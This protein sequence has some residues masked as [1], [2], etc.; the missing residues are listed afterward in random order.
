MTVYT[1]YEPGTP[2]GDLLEGVLELRVDIHPN[3]KTVFNKPL[4]N[5]EETQHTETLAQME[6]QY[7]LEEKKIGF[8]FIP[9]GNIPV[10]LR[11]G[12]IEAGLAFFLSDMRIRI[13][14]V[15]KL[16]LTE[17]VFGVDHMWVGDFEQLLKHS[18][19]RAY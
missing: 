5:I 6:I 10:H 8:R 1:K 18:K 12:R 2:L 14:G 17:E 11:E 9:T 15:V 7:N 4:K 16:I 3:G 13:Q 19:G